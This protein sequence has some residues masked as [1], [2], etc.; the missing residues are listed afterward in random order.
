MSRLVSILVRRAYLLARTTPWITALWFRFVQ[1]GGF[2]HRIWHQRLRRH[3][4]A[5]PSRLRSSAAKV[6]ATAASIPVVSSG[7][8]HVAHR[9]AGHLK[10]A[11]LDMQPI[12]PAVGGGRL[13][14][15]GLYHALGPQIEARYVGTYDWPGEAYRLQQLSPVLSE[16][17]VPLSDEHHTAARELSAQ[18]RGKT[19]IDIAFHTQAYLSPT[20]LEATRR[21][22]AWADVLVFSHPWIFPLVQEAIRPDQVVIYD[23]HNVESVLRA[24]LLDVRHDVEARLL[25]GVIEAEYAAGSRAD[26]VLACSQED[27]LIFE[28]IYD[29]SPAKMRV[30]PN[31]VMMSAIVPVPAE[32][33]PGLRAGLGVP[34][35]RPAAIFIGSD[36]GPNIEA[37]RFIVGQL[38]PALPQVQFIIAGGVGTR[39]DAGLSNVTVTGF[40]DDAAKLAWLQASD[41]ALNPMFSGSGTNIKMFDFMA[42]G[43]PVLATAVGARGISTGGR[44][45]LRVIAPD[46]QA[47]VGA[48]Q[49]LIADP[50]RREQMGLEARGCVEDDY[51]WERI[52]RQ[53]GLLMQ[54]AMRARRGLRPTFSVVVPSYDRHAHL[55]VLMQSLRAQDFRDFEVIVVDQTP[56]E[57]AGA[58]QDYGFP[59]VYVHSPVKGAARARNFGGALA[60]GSIIAFTDDD[61][62]PQPDWLAAATAYFADPQVV[63]VE[64][65]IDSDHLNDPAFRPVTNVG[66]EGIG[67]MTANLL[68]RR[69]EFLRLG[70]FDLAFDRPHFR[71]DTDFGWRL[72]ER[73][74]V[75]YAKEVRV[76][77]PAQPRTIERES[78]VARA[79]FFEKDALLYAKHPRRYMELFERE[80]QWVHTEAFWEH[81]FR[82]GEKYGVDLSAFKTI[83]ARRGAR[84]A[85]PTRLA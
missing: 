56:A 36:Y 45:A 72:Q 22:V 57:W 5:T 28:R 71:E 31:G 12:T 75:P 27:L 25:R 26:L 29:W 33:K 19:V 47:F 32:Q 46:A 40:I 70:G 58:E 84:H 63:G 4:K 35:E 79:R 83:A 9:Q 30:V 18:T 50:P 85:V 13:R 59:L 52:S 41:L 15:L 53:L 80:A 62:R 64:G 67:F 10:V 77:H 11:I 48:I 74:L 23:S 1:P 38:A 6:Q 51:A 44:N 37:A 14:L 20:Y 16:E 78:V 55:D 69:E 3:L 42:A 82:G 49:A 60:N 54:G 7:S 66:F 17:I 39:I 73:G 24:Q 81:F 34:A 21:Q 76:L 61:C 43:L 65:R 2:V 68:V 8:T